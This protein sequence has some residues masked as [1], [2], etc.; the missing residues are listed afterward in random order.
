MLKEQY[1]QASSLHSLSIHWHKVTMGREHVG[2]GMRSRAS[3]VRIDEDKITES[4]SEK[5]SQTVKW[6]CG[7]HLGPGR[8]ERTMPTGKQ[9]HV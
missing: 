3:S 5:A 7:P 4:I 6:P 2:M 9:K 1:T 8:L